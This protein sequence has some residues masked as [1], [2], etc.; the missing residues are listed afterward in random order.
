[1]IISVT[2]LQRDENGRDEE[3]SLETPGIYG[4]DGDMKYVTY[5]ETKLAGMEGTTTTLRI[6][7]DRV[8]LMREGNFLQSQDYLMG[9]TCTSDYE[10]PMGSLEVSVM[11]REIEDSI[12]HG[13]G[14]MRLVYDVELKGL[15]THLNEIIVDVREDPEYSWKSEK[16]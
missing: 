7:K 6:Y 5:R 2:S 9:E 1:M 10:T 8:N 13:K 12:V 14:R 3:I 4:E 16:N 11:T 15:F